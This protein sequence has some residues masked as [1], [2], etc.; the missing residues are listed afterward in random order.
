MSCNVGRHVLVD[1]EDCRAIQKTRGRV[2]IPQIFGPRREQA[3]PAGSLS[4]P[5]WPR[6]RRLGEGDR[7]P[8]WGRATGLR[9]P[10]LNLYDAERKRCRT[11][12]VILGQRVEREP[13]QRSR[14]SQDPAGFGSSG[15][16]NWMD[17]LNLSRDVG[18]D[19]VR[20]VARGVEK[21]EM[22]DVTEGLGTRATGSKGEH[23]RHHRS[24]R[25]RVSTRPDIAARCSGAIA[26]WDI[27][28]QHPG[29]M[30]RGAQRRKRAAAYCARRRPRL[31]GEC[32]DCEGS[33]PC[34]KVVWPC[35]TLDLMYDGPREFKHNQGQRPSHW[36]RT[37]RT[38]E[39]RRRGPPSGQGGHAGRPQPAGRGAPTRKATGGT[40]RAG[41]PEGAPTRRQKASGKGRQGAWRHQSLQS[42]WPPRPRMRR[43][44]LRADSC[45]YLAISSSCRMFRSYVLLPLHL[46]A[47]KTNL[48]PRPGGP[49]PSG[50][51]SRARRTDLLGGLS[52]VRGPWQRRAREWRLSSSKIPSRALNSFSGMRDSDRPFCRAFYSA[53]L[54]TFRPLFRAG[55]RRDLRGHDR[56]IGRGSSVRVSLHAEAT[57]LNMISRLAFEPQMGAGHRRD[58]QF[59]RKPDPA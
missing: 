6:P 42:G 26:P 4:V 7:G 28:A 44:P 30:N 43:R 37:A 39:A 25:P 55:A 48:R 2:L 22:N 49:L 38:S 23:D 35:A 46:R 1:E 17:D 10:R 32:L 29:A 57:A 27:S 20:R 50:P 54:M 8:R 33:G 45:T 21:H 59:V 11:H 51:R 24:R 16:E 14:R 47:A 18:V 15:L 34:S 13:R 5:K 41:R 36:P 58:G 9:W 53:I 52:P 19:S 56:P 3:P 40:A 31:P 12:G